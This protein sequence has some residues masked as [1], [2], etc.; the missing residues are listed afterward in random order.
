[1]NAPLV[2]ASRFSAVIL[3]GDE[4][5]YLTLFFEQADITRSELKAAH[6]NNDHDAW[7]Q[8][9]HRFKGSAASMGFAAMAQL[10]ET[11]QHDKEATEEERA[12]YLEQVDA[13]IDALRTHFNWEG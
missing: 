3:R 11:I 9:A 4:A 2:D 7:H 5:K 12:V 1:M 6:H 10:M 8:T 13:E